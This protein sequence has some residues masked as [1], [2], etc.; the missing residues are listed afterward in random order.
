[1]FGFVT[2][3]AQLPIGHFHAV[4]VA[5][6]Q[7]EKLATF[8]GMFETQ[9]RA[10]ML[11]FGFPNEEKGR[12]DYAIEVPAALSIL[13]GM[14]PETEVKG[15]NDYPRDEWP[16]V[17]WTFYTFHLMFYLGMYFIFPRIGLVDI[18]ALPQIQLFV[19][20]LGGILLGLV[21][22]YILLVILF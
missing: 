4:Q 5:Q 7:P 1:M 18:R 6:T 16:P 15:L 17:P 12:V 13:V 8:E 2:A 11:L 19:S 20:I 10:P 22:I 3:A 21:F 9:K 14:D